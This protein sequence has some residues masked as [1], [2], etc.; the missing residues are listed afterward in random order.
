MNKIIY[1]TLILFSVFFICSGCTDKSVTDPSLQTIDTFNLPNPDLYLSI[2]DLCTCTTS[3]DTSIRINSKEPLI[4]LVHGCEGSAGRFRA[5]AQVFAFHGQ[6]AICFYYDDRD[7]LVKSSK[8]LTHALE[9]IRSHMEN[10]EITVIGHSLGGLI[11][12]RSLVA[13]SNNLLQPKE[14]SIR[15]VTISAPFSGIG[16]AAHCASKT[17]RVLTLGL[18]VP[19]CKFISGDKWYQITSPSPFIQQPGKLVKQVNEHLMVITDERDSCR[20]YNDKGVC[21]EDDFVFTV[22]EQ[23]FDKV[24]MFPFVNKVDAVAGHVEIVGDYRIPPKKL[25]TLLQ[26]NGIMNKTRMDMQE[27][28]SILFSQLYY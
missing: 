17:A 2:P 11:A 15:L 10:K 24:Y 7:S 9:T 13:D 28:F 23:A 8:K 21:I 25:I 22:Q 18:S 1:C 20:V 26:E 16:S 19:I 6:Q 14:T 5:I 27:R 12:R 3:S 4:L